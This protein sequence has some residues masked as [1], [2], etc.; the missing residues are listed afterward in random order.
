MKKG[1]SYVIYLRGE[2]T[3]YGIRPMS[4]L[5]RNLVHGYPTIVLERAFI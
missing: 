5:G 2:G 4:H 1:S 3:R